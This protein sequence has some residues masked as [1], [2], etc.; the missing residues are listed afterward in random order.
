MARS[1]RVADSNLTVR[2]LGPFGECNGAGNMNHN[3]SSRKNEFSV[4]ELPLGR[5]AADTNVIEKTRE[6]AC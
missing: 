1:P 3:A 5:C 6:R 2:R 4:F